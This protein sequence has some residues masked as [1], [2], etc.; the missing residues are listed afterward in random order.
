MK[1]HKKYLCIFTLVVAASVMY[2][3]TKEKTEDALKSRASTAELMAAMN[4][5]QITQ[6]AKAPDFELT[7]VTGRKVS[8]SQYRGK[9]VFL[10]FWATW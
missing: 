1:K 10:S 5:Q 2:A 9:V 6:P 3:C 8:L 7:S 4:I